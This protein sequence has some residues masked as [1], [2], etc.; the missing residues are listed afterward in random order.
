MLSKPRARDLPFDGNEPGTPAFVHSAEELRRMCNTFRSASH[1]SGATLLYTL[2]ACAA[3]PVLELVRPHVTGFGVSSQFEARLA[4]EVL[5]QEKSVHLTATALQPED[6]EWVS[7]YCDYVTFN[8]VSQF[9]LLFEGISRNVSCGL[10]INPEISF[11]EDQ[12]YDPC[13][14][15]SKLGANLCAID[16]NVDLRKQIADRLDGLHFHTN[17]GQRDWTQILQTAVTVAERAPWLCESVRWINLGGGYL[18]ADHDTNLDPLCEAVSL[19]KSQF[20]LEVFIEPGA[21]IVDSAGFLVASVVDIF[22][23]GDATIVI[24]DTTINHLPEVFEY[25][26]EPDVQGHADDGQFKYTIAGCSCLAGDVFGHYAFHEPLDVGSKV[27]FENVGAYQSFGEIRG[28]LLI[29]ELEQHLHP[30]LQRTALDRLS[31]LLPNMQIIATTHSPFV[32]QDAS[33]SEIIVLKRHKKEVGCLYPAP[34]TTGYSI[35][36]VIVD[37]RIFDTLPYSTHDQHR[38]EEIAD[39]LAGSNELDRKEKKR[40]VLEL[41]RELGLAVPSLEDDRPLQEVLDE[42]R[43]QLGLEGTSNDDSH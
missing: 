12:R 1:S 42:F 5:G 28:I 36:D 14:A 11:V 27:I 29:D 23:S 20:G 18:I 21:G 41:L 35:Q 19:F 4:R 25:Q 32:V 30:S 7:R 40:R 2:K 24:L 43:Q 8:S 34:D 38:K 9:N 33:R 13:R 22:Q 17:H 37:A 39:L 6:A 15:N 31:K 3:V 26:F 10:R 16:V